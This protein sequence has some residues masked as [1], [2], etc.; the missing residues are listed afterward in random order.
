MATFR[1]LSNSKTNA[2]PRGFVPVGRSTFQDA[3]ISKQKLLNEETLAMT[4]Q[5]STFGESVAQAR[6]SRSHFRA[7]FQEFPR[8]IPPT[9]KD[10]AVDPIGRSILVPGVGRTLEVKIASERADLESAFRL[11][12]AGYRARGYEMPSTKLFR[13]SPYHVLPDTVTV[14][15]KDRDRVVATLS[16]VP[17][18]SLLGLPMECIYARE[19]N[20]LRREGRRLA[21]PTSLADCD[22]A[23][24]EFLLVFKTFIKVIFQYHVRRGGD[25]W[26]ITVNPRHRNFYLKVL[27]FEPLGPCRSY[28]YVQDHPA[29]AFFLDRELLVSKAPEMHRFIFGAPLPEPVL[30]VRPWSVEQVAYFGSQSTLTDARTIQ[31]IALW[32]KHFGSPPRWLESGAPSELQDSYIKRRIAENVGACGD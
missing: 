2:A 14:V 9:A 15:A 17:D 3:R 27:G 28:P 5:L 21:E 29:E 31:D 4:A 7:D 26:V 30:K 16:L 10:A 13:Y 11:L 19:L 6:H 12:A 20:E 25:S 24:R 32:V 8:R 18:T 22:L 1:N 23:A